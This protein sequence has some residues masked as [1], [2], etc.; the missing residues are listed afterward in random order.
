[1]DLRWW[2][3]V[4]LL[5]AA[6][7]GC[8][9]N[10]DGSAAATALEEPPELPSLPE[11]IS[12]F[13]AVAITD[14]E[15]SGQ[16]IWTHGDTLYM[17]N[18]G[19]LNLADISDP[20]DPKQLGAIQDIGARDVD[21]LEW[22]GRIYAVLAGSSDGL[23]VVDVTDPMRPT[24]TGTFP[25][26]SA[27]VHNLAAVPG[28][29]YV[30]ASGASGTGKAIDV[31]D[32][33][34]PANPLIHT[35]PIPA[36]MGGIPVESDG[37]HD[38]TVRA[39][40]ERAYCAGGGGTYTGL[41]GET[42]IWDISEGA[43]GVTNPTWVAMIDDPRLKY[44]HQAFVNLEG[45]I[46]IIN[47]EFIAPNCVRV[48]TPLP[49][50]A[51]PQ[52]PFAAAWIYDVSDESS[53]QQMAFIQNPSGIEADEGGQPKVNC[54]SHFGDIV[55]GHDAFVMGWYQGGTVLV[56]F[57]DPANPLLLDIADAAGGSTWDARVHGTYVLHSSNDLIVTPLE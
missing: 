40:L 21:V 25:L 54:G 48:E 47:D 57:S 28:T 20:M 52:V 7:A 17:T 44:H 29:P 14:L 22:D 34:D 42:F 18:G 35:F 12:R 45:T 19:D 13:G 16:G 33:S 24:L 23:H 46:L 36:T 41:G 27:G 2:M 26:P 37:C 50:A 5:M 1:M 4:P 51:D 56:D 32:I 43:G 39:D 30:Y 8:L 55:L 31:V 9:D 3:T 10:E 6:V 49:G 11:T 53:P 38:I 15:G